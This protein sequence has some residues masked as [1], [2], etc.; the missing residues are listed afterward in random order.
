MVRARRLPCYVDDLDGFGAHIAQAD[1]QAAYDLWQSIAGQVEKLSDR[2]FH[3][4]RGRKPGAMELVAHPRYLVLLNET[5]T[6][7]RNREIIN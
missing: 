4:R 2:N 5:E 7:V 6:T 1:Q 3:R